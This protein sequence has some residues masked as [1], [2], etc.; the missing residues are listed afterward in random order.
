MCKQDPQFSRVVLCLWLYVED[1]VSK[2]T[3]IDSPGMQEAQVIFGKGD[4]KPR[5]SG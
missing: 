5:L 4:T 3:Y 2:T 1:I